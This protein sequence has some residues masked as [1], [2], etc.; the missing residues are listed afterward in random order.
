LQALAQNKAS[1]TAAAQ[2]QPP[3]IQPK[4]MVNAP[5]DRYEQE[6]DA[7]AERVMRM[8]ESKPQPL[9]PT[10]TGLIARSIQRKCAACESEEE[11]KKKGGLLM[12]KA[13]GGGG[14]AAPPALVSQLNATKGGGAPLPEGTR[15]FMENA[16]SADFSGVRVHTDGQAAEM[17]RSI[18]AKAFTYGSDIY[19]NSGQFA[20]ERGEGK[21]LLAHELGHLT[22]QNN[23]APIIYRSTENN[24]D[25]RKKSFKKQVLAAAINRLHD[26]RESLLAWQVFILYTLNEMQANILALYQAGGLG[27]Y[28]ELQDI[29]NPFLREVR[30][31]Q[32]H[33]EW[34]ACTG[35]HM[36]IAASNY[37]K[38][39]TYEASFWRSPNEMRQGYEPQALRELREMTPPALLE[40]LSPQ[41]YFSSQYDATAYK[42]EA[43]TYAKYDITAY[44]PKANTYEGKLNRMLPDPRI[45]EQEGSLISKILEILGDSGFKVLPGKLIYKFGEGK[46][47]EFRNETSKNIDERRENYLKL[48]GKIENKELDYKYFAPIIE[49]FFKIYTDREVI[50]AI[51]DEMNEKGFWYWAEQVV[52][53]ALTAISLLLTIFPPTSAAGIALLGASMAALATYGV[54]KAPEM[55]AV[56]EAFMLGRGANNVFTPEQQD[57]GQSIV[58]DAYMNILSALLVAIGVIS[59]VKNIYPKLPKEHTKAGLKTTNIDDFQITALDDGTILATHK[60]HPELLIIAKDNYAKMYYT[61]GPGQPVTLVKEGAISRWRTNSNSAIVPASTSVSQPFWATSQ[62]SVTIEPIPYFGSPRQLAPAPF[63]IRLIPESG[64]ENVQN[65]IPWRLGKMGD[66]GVVY[67]NNP[68]A[69]TK[70]SLVAS[71]SRSPKKWPTITIDSFSNFPDGVPI[72]MSSGYGV[73]TPRLLPDNTI[74]QLPDGTKIWK[75]YDIELKRWVMVHDYAVSPSKFRLNHQTWT[76]PSPK[77]MGLVGYQRTHAVGPI[78]SLVV[79]NISIP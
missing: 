38:E 59:N 53:A 1:R 3:R 6:A 29:R 27:V 36:E 22:Q 8:P 11:K 49:Y 54:M 7:M 70:S 21:R 4:L 71:G 77:K 46:Y 30:A 42:P 37:E 35:C 48:I 5:G 75:T 26:N 55:I 39:H 19:F 69:G 25:E 58:F 62:A 12:R 44:S 50:K 56:G 32:A 66:G 74:L 45:V 67:L 64:F 40:K 52:L 9:R 47:D 76:L 51:Q 14:F 18:Q 17:S 65:L 72:V 23:R 13:E 16:F 79:K 61:S 78:T 73:M 63:T 10:A 28:M 41:N 57:S 31:R 60:N 33:R 43:S 24:L 34:R 15:S 68:Y 20:P 2:K